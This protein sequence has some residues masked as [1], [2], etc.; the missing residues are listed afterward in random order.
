MLA[1]ALAVFVLGGL[2]LLG[3]AIAA[4]A[5][6]LQRGIQVLAARR[7]A[8][9]LAA[10]N[11]QRAMGALAATMLGRVWLMVTAALLAGI[12]DREAGLAAA[13]LL[14][15]AS[16]NAQAAHVLVVL[17]D[18]DHLDLRDGQVY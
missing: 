13:V 16:T 17:S 8:A 5:W 7:V 6:L 4:A 14:A 10:G 15:V 9:E 18:A 12:A 2:P 1:A 11:R 3:Y